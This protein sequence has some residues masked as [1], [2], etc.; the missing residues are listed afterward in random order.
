MCAL[1]ATAR[2]MGRCVCVVYAPLQL[3][4]GHLP[5]PAAATV[6][7]APRAASILTRADGCINAVLLV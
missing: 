5:P 1:A 2:A 7:P 6:V 3:S 4:C